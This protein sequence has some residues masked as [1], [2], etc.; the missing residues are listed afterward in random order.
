M[1]AKVST[2]RLQAGDR[3]E[4][5]GVENAARLLRMPNNGGWHIA[6]GEKYELTE[7]GFRP[8][9]DTEGDKDSK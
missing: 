8:I 7:N 9:K 3:I 6:D 5:F 2:V 4:T 1:N